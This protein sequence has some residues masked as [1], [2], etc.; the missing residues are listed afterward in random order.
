MNKHILIP[1]AIDHEAIVPR[2]I[3]LARK[4]LEPGGK[5]TLITVL[6]RVSGFVAEFVTV[7]SE[8]HLSDRIRERLEKAAGGAEEIEVA[9]ATGKPGLE[10]SRYARDHHCDLIIMGSQ[11]PD[12]EGYLLGSTAQRVVRRAPCS[13]YVMR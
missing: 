2:K 3:E 10:I 13:V 9:V 1:V 7:K 6:E 12:E 4:L 8:N 5:I 11:N